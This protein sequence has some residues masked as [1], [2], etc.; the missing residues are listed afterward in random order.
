VDE[1]VVALR[2]QGED[3]KE[4]LVRD[5]DGRRKKRRK[6]TGRPRGGTLLGASEVHESAAPQRCPRE[7]AIGFE[8]RRGHNHCLM[9]SLVSLR[10]LAG[11]IWSRC[12]DV[13]VTLRETAPLRAAS[14]APNDALVT[15]DGAVGKAT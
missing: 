10:W 7:P 1:E 12:S 6:I 14:D 13:R 9:F 4:D 5:C 11:A 2:R 8:S 15:S 3:V